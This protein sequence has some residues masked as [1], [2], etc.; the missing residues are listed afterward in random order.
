MKT[1]VLSAVLGL[2]LVWPVV[3]S[4][5]SFFLREL[6]VIPV[7]QIDANSFEA[8]E[9]DG[10]GGTLMWCAAA[11]FTRD[12][13]RQRG[14]DIGVLQARG[15]SAVFAGRKSV[16]FTTAP[17]ANPVTSYSEDVRTPGKTLSMAHAYALCRSNPEYFVKVRVVVP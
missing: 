3:L 4:A 14:G 7:R 11:K 9:N 1:N 17:V 10:A 13:L 16:I 6:V 5:Q 15:P 12:H 8:V 2:A